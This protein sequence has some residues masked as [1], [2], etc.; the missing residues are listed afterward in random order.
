MAQLGQSTTHDWEGLRGSIAGEVILPGSP[1]YESARK[2]AIARFHDTMPLAV[3]V[4]ATPEDV[5]ETISCARR[6]G[7]GATTRSGGHCFSGRSST[8]GIVIDVSPMRPVSVSGGVATVGAGAHL[9]DVYDA[10]DGHGITIPAGCGPSVGISGLTLGGGMGILGRKHGLTSDSL[11]GAQVVLADGRIV[12]CDGQNEPDLFWALRGAGGC[13]FGVV[14]SLIFGT[15]PAPDATAFHLMWPH[16]CAAAIV[17]AWQVWSPAAPDELTAG[18][19]VFAPDDPGQ[20]PVVSMFGVMLGPESEVE[21]L[22][23][24]LVART[25]VDPSSAVLEHASYREI[26]HYLAE[27]GLGDHRP[28]GHQFSKSEFFRRPLPQEAVAALVENLSEGRVQGE[29][30]ELD[31][32]PWAGAYNRV[33]AEATA[34]AH[35]D[36]R[37][38]LLQ[39][40]VVEPDAS[41]AEREA[42]RGWLGRSWASVHPWG[43]GGVYPNFPDPNLEDWPR[44]YHGLNL[45]RL[46]H[47][48]RRY[49]PDGFFRFHQSI[50]RDVPPD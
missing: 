10:L 29:S 4:C 15:V 43:S 49:D 26:K 35:R 21:N 41:T 20:S 16:A 3:V 13:N 39:V 23:E 17:S 1:D 28:D 42:A 50:P 36:E 44:A 34:F 8:D 19:R 38:L 33:P 25:G 40:A 30:R 18:L 27:H 5:S 47:L 2:P 11:L 6:S 32:T 14:T 31:F 22:L 7:L 24:E 9:G 48:K 46:V 12:E 37:F 45:E